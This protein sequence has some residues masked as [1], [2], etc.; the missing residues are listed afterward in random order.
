M[1]TFPFLVHTGHLEQIHL[2][3]KMKPLIDLW[4]FKAG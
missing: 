1:T 3:L 2:L 4:D